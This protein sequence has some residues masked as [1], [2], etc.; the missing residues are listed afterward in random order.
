[1]TIRTKKST[2]IV[3]NILLTILGLIWIAP[4]LFVV[5]NVFKTK[6]EYNL[7]SFWKLPESFSPLLDNIANVVENRLFVSVGSSLLYACVGA[8]MA[9]FIALLAAYGLTHLTVKHKMF[10]FLFIYSGTIFP[11]Q[12]YLIPIYRGYYKLGLYNTRIGMILFYCAISIPFAMFVLR[13]FMLGISSEICESAK[14]DGASNWQVLVRIFVPMAKAPLS[15][16][17]LSQFS[18]SWNDL[19]FGLT[20]TKSVDIR[21]IM[22]SLSLMN[23]A[24]VPALFLACLIVSVPTIILYFVLQDNFTT[25]FAYTGK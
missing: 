24:H 9:V 21:P 14:I 20:F 1:M 4:V 16:V 17:F 6:Q 15:I 11:F 8:A 13:N 22:A 10:W 25:G 19:M 3:C 18:W 2:T 23:S 12:V 5:L 7:G